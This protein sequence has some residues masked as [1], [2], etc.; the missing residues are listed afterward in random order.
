MTNTPQKAVIYCRVS[1]PKQKHEGHGL[2]SQAHRCRQF[3]EEN[4]FILDTEPFF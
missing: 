3:V 4:G 2:E 1:D